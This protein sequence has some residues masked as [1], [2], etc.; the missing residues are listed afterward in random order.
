MKNRLDKEIVER[1]LVPSRSKSQEL[2]NSSL[3]KVNDKIINKCNFMVSSSDVITILDNDKLKYVSR[4]GLKL[5]KAI[6][7]FKI[8][9]KGKRVMDIGSS[10]GG[11]CDCALKHGA[12]FIRAIDVGTNLLHSSLRN[13]SRIE[14]HEQTNF[15][16]LEHKYFTDIDIMT[17]DV[18][19]I[20]LIKIIEKI[21]LENVKVDM[22]CL[23]KPQ[24]ECGKEIATK[25]KGIILDKSVHYEIINRII[26]ELNILNLYLKN[27]TY[28]PIKG[29]DGNIEYLCYINNKEKTNIK[30]D[31]NELIN[32]AF[33]SK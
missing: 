26:K 20:S 27:I 13:D 32:K 2:I 23:I 4:G 19:F 12:S 33:K 17:C 22:I 29:G 28:S 8:D 15:K 7:E 3:V 18:S 10:T 6:I 24:F 21:S 30:F 1:N 16:D 14:L 25:Y 9:F 5:E 31:V 11:F